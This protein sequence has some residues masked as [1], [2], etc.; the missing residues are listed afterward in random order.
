MIRTLL[1]ALACAVFLLSSATSQTYFGS[2]TSSSAASPCLPGFEGVSSATGNAAIGTTIRWYAIDS[3]GGPPTWMVFHTLLSVNPVSVPGIQGDLLVSPV[4]YV[5]I[6]ATPN[7]PSITGASYFDW[8]IPNDPAL[9]NSW[10]HM[11]ALR[12]GASGLVLS[13]AWGIQIG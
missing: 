1:L 9:I 4:N 2:C 3:V 7:H 6:T 5:V 13:S 10:L 12:A 11:Q 8:P